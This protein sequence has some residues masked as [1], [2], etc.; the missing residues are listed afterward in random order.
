M[1][2][3][4]CGKEVEEW[5]SKCPYCKINF[6]KYE[7]GEIFVK[8][9]AYWLK[10]FAIV[11]IV[12]SIIASIIIF[13]NYSTIDVIKEYDYISGTYTETVINWIGII[14]GIAV[15]IMGFTIYFTLRTIVDIHNMT[16][17]INNTK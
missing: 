1:K 17:E 16:E 9:N 14:G 3:P 7:Q 10:I 11:N 13:V 15:L 6:E 4:K 5:A 8:N 2:C 12:L